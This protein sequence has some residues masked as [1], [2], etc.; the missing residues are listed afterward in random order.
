MGHP[1]IAQRVVS[2]G[3]RAL[4][5]GGTR[6]DPTMPLREVAIRGMSMSMCMSCWSGLYPYMVDY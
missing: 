5:R 2:H 1:W 4:G 3:R 6:I